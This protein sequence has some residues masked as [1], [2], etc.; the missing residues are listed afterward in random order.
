MGEHRCRKD[1]MYGIGNEKY[2]CRHISENIDNGIDQACQNIRVR[3]YNIPAYIT[4]DKKPQ[5]RFEYLPLCV[6]C[7]K[8]WELS[9]KVK[10]E[11]SPD[12]FDKSIKKYDLVEVCPE[13]LQDYLD[14][15]KIKD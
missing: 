12:L 8:T 6:D 1:H 14:R 9:E 13:C 3:I 4:R 10:I 7:M 11:Y 2:A 15:N 5:E